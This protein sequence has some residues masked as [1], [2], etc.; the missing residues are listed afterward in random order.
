M[1]RSLNPATGKLLRSFEPI[2]PE[3]LETRLALAAAAARSYPTEPLEQRR[4]W[5][6]RLAL[7]LEAD[8]EE[9]ACLLVTEVG[10]TI[11]GARAEIDKCVQ[12]CRH[13]AEHAARMLES[14][15]IETEHAQSFVRWDPLGVILA[16]MPWN[17]PLW[18]VFR[19]LAPVLMAGNVALLRH[20]SGVPQCA[21]AI[22]TLVRRAGFPRGSFQTL[23]VE[24]EAVQGLLA[25]RRIAAVSVTGSEAA[26]RAVAAQAGHLLK[27]SVLELGGSDPFI[28]MPSADLEAAIENAVQSRCLNN[29]QSCIAAKRFLV[30]DEVYDRFEQGFVA[31]MEALRVGDPTEES[32][33]VGP[34]QS[35]AAVDKLLHQMAA[36][37][38]SGGELLTGGKGISGEGF[39]VE[40]TAIAGVPPEAAICKE[41]TLGPLALLF[42]VHSLDEALELANDTPFGLGASCWT[43][44]VEEQNRMAAEI[45][46]GSVFFNT[47]VASDPR[48]PFGGVKQSGFG[49]E[50]SAAGMREFLNAKT[51]VVAQHTA[52]TRSSA[53]VFLQE[54]QM[55]EPDATL[56]E[57]EP[58]VGP[59]AELE[60]ASTFRFRTPLVKS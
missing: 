60:P 40:P 7:L 56:N 48:L 35:A 58:A 44:D 23:L 21:L 25:D 17:F 51:V 50:L 32:T 4:F 36:A 3:L 30:H 8:R 34:L 37:L 28:V 41:E 52:A 27:K 55:M 22:E 15:V 43:K 16:V 18:Q 12:V 10:K 54:I 6:R 31:E 26:G 42:R 5:M 14:E 39:Y 46:A 19:F 29:G 11:S 45:Q 24:E 13:F 1:I 49:R 57:K 20:D 53:P 33:D 9:L 59:E 38:A 2:T 47:P